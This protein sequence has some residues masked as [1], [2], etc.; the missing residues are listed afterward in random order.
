MATGEIDPPKITRPDRPVAPATER[1]DDLGFQLGFTTKV[2]NDPA[3]R[4][5]LALPYANGYQPLA[6][7]LGTKT[8]TILIVNF[9]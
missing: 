3:P 2:D 5:R 1:L 8:E 7:E 4:R 9:L 6:D